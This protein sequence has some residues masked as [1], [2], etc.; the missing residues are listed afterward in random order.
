MLHKILNQNRVICGFLFNIVYPISVKFVV[1]PFLWQDWLKLQ[2]KISF[3]FIF[4]YFSFFRIKRVN[5]GT[6]NNPHKHIK[7]IKFHFDMRIVYVL[8]SFCIKWLHPSNIVYILTKRYLKKKRILY[9]SQEMRIG[10]CVLCLFTFHLSCYLLSIDSF[11][12]LFFFFFSFFFRMVNYKK[13]T[14]W[15]CNL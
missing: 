4:L 12:F 3:F 13:Y 14:K 11:L 9:L 10:F 2:Y 8:W 7:Y 6:I 5:E 15:S 1:N